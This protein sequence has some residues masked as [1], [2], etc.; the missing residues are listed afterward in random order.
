MKKM[1]QTKESR[2]ERE[3]HRKTQQG[4]LRARKGFLDVDLGL[5]DKK[6]EEKRNRYRKKSKRR[7]VERNRKMAVFVLSLSFL[8]F[9]FPFCKIPINVNFILI[10]ALSHV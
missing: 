7:Y 2:R 4:T 9:P 1:G 6:G 3:R 5:L 10:F 8:F